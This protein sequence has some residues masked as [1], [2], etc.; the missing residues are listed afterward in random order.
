MAGSRVV[1]R[2][3]RHDA[4][5]VVGPLL[6]L[7]LVWGGVALVRGANHPTPFPLARMQAR[8]SFTVVTDTARAQRVSDRLAGRGRVPVILGQRPHL[9]GQL[10]FRTVGTPADG[11]ELVLF[12]IDNRLHKPLRHLDGAGPRGEPFGEGWEGDYGRLATKYPWLRPLAAIR[13]ADG[14]YSDP[15][16]ALSFRVTTKAPVTFAGILDPDAPPLTDPAHDLSFVVAYV[17]R[18]GVWAQRIPAAAAGEVG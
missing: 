2:W 6:A 13:H 7:G 3:L 4:A 17:G 9:V 5:L 1:G 8:A 18:Q 12:V 11:G 15:G 10:R 14:S 16:A